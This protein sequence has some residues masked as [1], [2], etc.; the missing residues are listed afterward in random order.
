MRQ[1]H[2][3]LLPTPFPES[4]RYS[5]SI[6]AL[7]SCFAQNMSQRLSD[8]LF[9]VCTN[10]FGTLY[11]PLSI[12][13]ALEY[14]LDD[15]PISLD[16]LVQHEGQWFHWQFHHEVV[17]TDPKAVLEQLQQR[18]QTARQQ[19]RQA[20]C[21][22]LTW[23]TAWVYRL[24][25]SGTVVANC[26][27]VPAVQFQRNRLS[28]DEI[29]ATW[30]PLLERL[31]QQFPQLFIVGSISPI[32]HLKDGLIDNQRSKATLLLAWHELVDYH[33]NWVYYF[34]AY[35]LLL[36]DLRDYRY[37]SDNL[38]HPSPLAIDYIW[39]AFEATTLA[40]EEADLRVRVQRLQR[41]LAHRPRHPHSAA[42]QAFLQ[43][44]LEVLQTLAPHLPCAS[45]AKLRASIEAALVSFNVVDH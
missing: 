23:G 15:S 6:I 19:L 1:H 27:R 7:G 21:L 42:H 28:T 41:A 9:E 44:Q 3:T 36:D 33:S 5:D 35:E 11:N 17:G 10:P 14:L 4:L 18:L 34:P 29:L 13:Q 43:Q 26:H 30:S 12:A 37:Y 40:K 32:R 20:R 31:H 38:T 22:L 2:T 45:V 24:H 16:D 8:G 25:E 39:E